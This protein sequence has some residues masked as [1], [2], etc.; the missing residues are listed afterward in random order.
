MFSQ[1]EIEAHCEETLWGCSEV[2]KPTAKSLI[3]SV[4]TFSTTRCLYQK[5]FMDSVGDALVRITNKCH[6]SRSFCNIFGKMNLFSSLT[7]NNC[8]LDI[9]EKLPLSAPVW[10]KV[11]SRCL[12][13]LPKTKMRDEPVPETA[14]GWAGSPGQH[15]PMRGRH[16]VVMTNER[17]RCGYTLAPEAR[18]RP[19]RVME[20]SLGPQYSDIGAQSSEY[21]WS[22]I[23]QNISLW[24]THF[25]W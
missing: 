6:G 7:A 20:W 21:H 22:L 12:K 5:G 8:R 25:W 14:A 16:R 11:W 9:G 13:M 4:V 17:P 2:H 10:L 3:Y 23:I 1:G 19:G 18:L 15:W 24:K